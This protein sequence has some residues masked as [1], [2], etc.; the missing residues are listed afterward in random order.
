M[1]EKIQDTIVNLLLE[2]IQKKIAS[3]KEGCKWQKLFVDTGKFFLSNPEVLVKFEEDLYLVF[4]SEN[5][6]KIAN[7]LKDINGYNFH[8]ILHK[9]LYDLMMSYEIPINKAETYIHKFMEV[10]ITYLEE[11]YPESKTMEM[12]FR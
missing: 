7:K 10:I 1:I 5:L 4:S 11:N 3:V 12:F 2:G 6:G 9:E 8:K